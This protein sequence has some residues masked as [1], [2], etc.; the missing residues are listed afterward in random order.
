MTPLK[1]L[2]ADSISQ[3]GVDELLCDGALDVTIKTGLSEK[4]LIEVIPTFSALIVRSQTRVTADILNA[5]TK[6]RVVGRGGVGVDKVDV[7]SATRGG[8]VV[9]N[10]PGG[11]TVSTAE[12]AFSLLL[13]VA[14][15]I[16]HADATVS[17][18]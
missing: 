13:A 3:R 18:Q 15:K 9:L 6:L 16:P 14:R 10:A 12:Q 4:E 5:G 11:N 7:E 2:I 8:V 17:H 1:V